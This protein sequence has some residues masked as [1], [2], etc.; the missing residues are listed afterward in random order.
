MVDYASSPDKRIGR[1][2]KTERH[3]TP[4]G[5]LLLVE[6]FK[7]FGEER[8]GAE[9]TGGEWATSRGIPGPPQPPKQPKRD[10]RPLYNPSDGTTIMVE[11]GEVIYRVDGEYVALP[12]EEALKKF[13]EEKDELHEQWR[14]IEAAHGRYK[15]ACR[16]LRQIFHAGR[17]PTSI[18][19]KHGHMTP[20][21]DH[22]WSSDDAIKV[23]ETG[24]AKFAAGNTVF[25]VTVE[26]I[27]IVPQMALQEYINS[28]PGE[29]AQPTD[30]GS[31]AQA[32]VNAAEYSAEQI[33]PPISG[34]GGRPPKWDWDACWAE[35]CRR[36]HFDGLPVTQAELVRELQEW[37][38]ER[39]GDA[40]S[41]SQIK[42]RVS[43]VFRALREAENP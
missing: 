25:P 36:V 14:Q 3:W 22:I 38:V 10:P 43:K 20:I 34:T 40:P 5:Q 16:E 27:V 19:S 41:D 31:P 30:S 18:L 24:R 6:A 11:P 39:Y 15:K 28:S 42:E 37:F 9:W 4:E 32:D 2:P 21:P 26:G 33:G 7:L 29:R 8:F 23:I 1:S 12:Y 17:V 13:E 35:I